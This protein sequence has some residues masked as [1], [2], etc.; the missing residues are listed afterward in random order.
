MTS[1]VM[2][3]PARSSDLEALVKALSD[4]VPA[5]LPETVWQ[6]PWAWPSYAVAVDRE[7]TVVA[8]GSLQEIG[9]GRAEIRGLFVAPSHRGVGLAAAIMG[10]LLDQART[11]A[12]EVVCVTRKPGFFERFGFREAPPTW[13]GAARHLTPHEETGQDAPRVGMIADLQHGPP[14]PHESAA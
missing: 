6:L 7:G 14:R 8:G 13:V 11:R 3:R 2:L 5:C 4:I 10:Q 9:D 1:P 12:L